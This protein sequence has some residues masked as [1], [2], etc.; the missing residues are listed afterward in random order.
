MEETPLHPSPSEGRY[1]SSWYIRNFD[2]VNEF[3]VDFH[4]FHRQDGVGATVGDILLETLRDDRYK[5]Q[6]QL[7]FSHLYTGRIVEPLQHRKCEF[8]FGC[9]EHMKICFTVGSLLFSDGLLH[10]FLIILRMVLVQVDTDDANQDLIQDQSGT[11]MGE[12]VLSGMNDRDEEN[13]A[14]EEFCPD[15]ENNEENEE[16]ESA[17]GETGNQGEAVDEKLWDKVEDNPTTMDEKYENGPSVRDC[18]I[19]RELRAKDDA[20][21]ADEAGGLDLDKSEEQADENGNDETCE[22]MEN[23][24]MDKEDAYAD[25]TGLKLDEHD[26]GPE[27][28]CNMDEPESAEPMVEDDLDQKGNPADENNEGVKG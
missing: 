10:D 6:L 12:G 17:M 1:W 26:Q 20:S 13:F 22:G 25:P 16:L 8:L 27:D 14:R 28:D 3:E 15:D 11:G 23:M 7:N 24:N 4:A 18:G 19:D 21:A 9:P 5:C 2:L